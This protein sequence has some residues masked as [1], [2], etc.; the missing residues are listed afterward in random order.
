M[1]YRRRLQKI[2]N[3]T[4]IIS[5]PK[6]WINLLKLDKGSE[7]IIKVL[8]NK[9]LLIIP[10]KYDLETNIRES[11]AIIDCDK[12][13]DVV[14]KE[15]ISHYLAGRKRIILKSSNPD[16]MEKTITFI[17]ERTIGLEF[18]EKKDNETILHNIVDIDFISLHE[19]LLKE[20]RLTIF[21]LE[22]LIKA[23]KNRELVKLKDI[24]EYDNAVDKA[25]LLTLRQLT[26]TIT[27]VGAI[28]N[29]AEIIYL[30]LIAKSFERIAD[31]IVNLSKIIIY[32][33]TLDNIDKHLIKYLY[34][35]Y[36]S[37]NRISKLINK[38][39]DLN[40]KELI[41]VYN[42]VKYDLENV[43]LST[44]NNTNGYVHNE[45]KRIIG[46][47]IDIFESL[48][49]IVAIKSHNKLS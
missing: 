21:I 29:P 47:I 17:N 35:I 37:I 18:F 40:M 19:A 5:L 8:P 43:Q 14:L 46:Y 10:D 48:F 26:K 42:E 15:I 32:D 36:N 34:I 25:Y 45:L 28:S 27:S 4:F 20:I 41:T 9:T 22:E 24:H 1:H 16:T 44:I 13:I 2:G 11:T 33:N 12:D 31:H 7:V 23:T 6:K 38:I 30:T 49:D 39:N 3:S